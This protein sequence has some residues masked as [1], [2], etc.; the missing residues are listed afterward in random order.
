VIQGQYA[1]LR[2]LLEDTDG[3]LRLENTGDDLIIHLDRSKIVSEGVPALQQF[4]KT[5][6]VYKSTADVQRG[7]QFF[8][9]Y[10]EMTDEFKRHRQVSM[11]IKPNRTKWIQPNVFLNTDGTVHLKEYPATKEALIQSWAE[12]KV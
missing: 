5:L 8:D 2:I 11:K 10:S 3:L 9:K 4:L 1:I 12:R 6:Q 7:R